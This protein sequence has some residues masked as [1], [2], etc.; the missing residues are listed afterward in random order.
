MDTTQNKMKNYLV[1]FEKAPYLQ[2]VL[3]A[4]LYMQKCLQKCLETN[5]Y[6]P[7]DSLTNA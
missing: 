1:L 4:S 6:K 7:Q 5:V 3:G 2:L